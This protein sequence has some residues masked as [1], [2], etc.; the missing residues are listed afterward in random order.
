[1]RNAQMRGGFGGEGYNNYGEDYRGHTTGPGGGGLP[2]RRASGSDLL[3]R[4]PQP[5]DDSSPA[6]HRSQNIERAY[7]LVNE[8][9]DHRNYGVGPGNNRFGNDATGSRGE[10]RRGG[11]SG[12]GPR[13]YQRSDDRIREDINEGLTDDAMLDASEIDVTVQNREVTLTGSVRDRNERRRAE[14]IAEAVQGVTHVQNNLR[15]GQHQAGH[16]SGMEVGDSG[17]ATGNPGI[18]TAGGTAGSAAGGR[19]TGDNRKGERQ[20]T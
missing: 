18:G 5:G 16:R 11:H 8:G 19:T 1:M 10:V 6:D 14:D 20:A 9:R 12:R 4:T 7:T 15:V 13:N 2:Q 3:G 17:V